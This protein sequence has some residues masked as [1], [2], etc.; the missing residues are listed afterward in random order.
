MYEAVSNPIGDKGDVYAMKRV[1][2]KSDRAVRCALREFQIL[3]KLA[4]QEGGPSYIQTL[5]SSF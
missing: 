3:K 1:N 5:F 2:L 4:M